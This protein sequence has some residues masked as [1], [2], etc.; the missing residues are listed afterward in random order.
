MTAKANHQKLIYKGRVINVYKDNVTLPNGKTV[1]MD[2]VRHPGAAAIVAV[3]DEK[4][5]FLLKQFRYV[6]GDY[7]WEIPAGT[8]ES[9]EA[10][11]DCAKR[12]L[13]EE[14]GVCARSWKTLGE[15][16]P[17]PGYTDE[18]IHVFLAQQLIPAKQNLDPDEI[19]DV[20][21]VPFDNALAMIRD[22]RIADAKSITGILMARDF[23]EF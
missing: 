8:L 1:D 14:T 23:I 13:I 19:I 17:A 10:P 6:I 20:H 3:T 4:N 2:V 7:I 16:T 22:G 5:I 15:M 9:G 12:E 18:R 11:L 21:Q